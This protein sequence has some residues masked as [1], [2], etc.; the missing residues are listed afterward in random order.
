MPLVN[1]GSTALGT[2]AVGRDSVLAAWID[3]RLLI[4]CRQLDKWV[5][6]ECSRTVAARWNC[7][8]AAHPRAGN[9]LPLDD[10]DWVIGQV[11]QWLGGACA[12]A[13]Q[14]S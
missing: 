12:S 8:L 5:H 3:A 4:L 10:P 2:R 7:S 11:R 9:D 6:V 14:A 1:P 13:W